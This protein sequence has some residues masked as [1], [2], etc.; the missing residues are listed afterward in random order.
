MHPSL[1]SDVI[2]SINAKLAEFV[3]KGQLLGARVFLNEKLV[4]TETLAAGK[5]PID[6]EITTVP[7]LENMLLNQHITDTFFVNLAEKMITF[8]SSLKPTTV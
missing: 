7:P 5:F 3:N 4:T 2:M 8:A 6:Y 1:L